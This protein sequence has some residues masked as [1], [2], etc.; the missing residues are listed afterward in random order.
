MQALEYAGRWLQTNG[1][2]IYYSRP[3]VKDDDVVTWNDTA[4]SQ[5]RYTRSKDNSTIYAIVLAGFGAAPMPSGG[6]LPLAD[7]TITPGSEV[8]LL[9]YEHESNRT[10][11]PIQWSALADGGQQGGSGGAVLEVPSDIDQHPAISDP[12]MTFV[13]KGQPTTQR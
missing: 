9:G 13:I 8:F 3:L 12:G 4:S 7:V 5:V 10:L 2:A 1:E 6:K 11:I